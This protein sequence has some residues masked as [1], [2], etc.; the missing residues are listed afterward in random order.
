M[1]TNDMSAWFVAAT[2]RQLVRASE[3]AKEMGIL[4]VAVVTK[5]FSFEGNKRMQSAQNPGMDP[6]EFLTDKPVIDADSAAG[7]LADW[8][9]DSGLAWKWAD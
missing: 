5:P 6:F 9:N 3:I 1:A 2:E 4:T 7:K 8:L